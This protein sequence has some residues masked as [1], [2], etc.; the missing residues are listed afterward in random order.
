MFSKTFQI[1]ANL[2]YQCVILLLSGMNLFVMHYNI[3]LSEHFLW[4]NTV[5]LFV[6]NV[7]AV[8]FDV[9]ILFLLFYI[10]TIKRQRVSLAFCFFITLLW[11]LS[12]VIYSR[13]FHQYI[14]IS[15][16]S[17]AGTL[18]DEQ[19]IRYTLTGLRIYD[20]Y[21]LFSIL[22]FAFLIRKVTPLGHIFKMVIPILLLSLSLD[23]ISP[24]LERLYHNI[25]WLSLYFCT[26]FT[27]RKPLL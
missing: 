19:M 13:F 11:S 3:L 12:N 5:N 16:A 23:I 21:Y 25:M 20:I 2:K 4:K 10:I 6:E 24:I 14:S 26:K 17:Q 27:V 8:I 9:C 7:F 1:F 15:A 18:L 22:V